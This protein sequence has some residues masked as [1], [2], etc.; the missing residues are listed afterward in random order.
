MIFAERQAEASARLVLSAVKYHNT[1][2]VS[3]FRQ[4]TGRASP[5]ESGSSVTGVRLTAKYRSRSQR[6]L[7]RT[8]IKTG[9]RLCSVGA[10]EASDRTCR[11]TT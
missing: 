11:L 7:L 2:E 6:Y 3:L 4:M 10:V 5:Y 9:Q 1:A 8:V